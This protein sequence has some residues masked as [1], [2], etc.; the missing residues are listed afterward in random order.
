MTAR[1]II[2]QA[3]SIFV[4]A[5]VCVTLTALCMEAN[6]MGQEGEKSVTDFAGGYP[7]EQMARF[8]DEALRGD[9]AAAVKVGAEVEIHRA[10]FRDG[11]AWYEIAAE[12]GGKDAAES[13]VA[14]LTRHLKEH[15][16]EGYVRGN[17]RAKKRAAFWEK[18][19]QTGGGNRNCEKQPSFGAAADSANKPV[20]DIEKLEDKALAGD[21]KAA[22]RLAAHYKRNNLDLKEAVFWTRIAAQNG[23][24]A[25]QTSLAGYM[26]DPE[27]R[28]KGFGVA[29]D[30]VKMNERYEKRAA[31]WRTRAQ[32]GR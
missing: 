21:C 18:M 6:C 17:D 15:L 20:L 26:E 14:V 28:M 1:N 23:D 7:P 2:G 22:V 5:L 13:F 4:G 19:A 8:E 3:T 30:D 16:P 12:N 10:D 11:A 32:Q 9:T 27:M 25:A 24:K 31:F 29:G